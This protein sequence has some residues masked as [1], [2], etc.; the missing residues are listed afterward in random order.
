M[1]VNRERISDEPRAAIVHH[2]LADAHDLRGLVKTLLQSTLRVSRKHVENS[3]E[4]SVE[5]S[6]NKVDSYRA[7]LGFRQPPQ[8]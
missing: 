5:N 1:A 4:H 3:V 8:R 2:E 7:P 6:V